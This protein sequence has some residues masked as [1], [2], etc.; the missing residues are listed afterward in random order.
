MRISDLEQ[1]RVSI[2]DIQQVDEASF[3][4]EWTPRSEVALSHS[5]TASWLLKQGDNVCAV[6]GASGTYEDVL[7]GLATRA[8]PRLAWIVQRIPP[9]GISTGLSIQ[10]HEFGGIHH[11]SEP[12]EIG[13]DSTL[14][15]DMRRRRRSLIS[16]QSLVEWLTEQLF[17]P[18]QEPGGPARTLLSGSPMPSPGQRPV[19]NKQI[20]PW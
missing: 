20:G 3:P 9:T 19:K 13:L 16:V 14:V 12:M 2:L 6:R 1:G 4:K 5:A 18:P 8:L 7:R 10:V 11:W 15:E 17:L